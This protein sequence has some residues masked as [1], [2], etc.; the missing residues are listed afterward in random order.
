MPEIAE[1][2]IMARQLDG[3][4]S[5]QRLEAVQVEDDRLQALPWTQLRGQVVRTVHRRGKYA[6]AEFAAGF[7]LCI[8]YRMTGKTVLDPERSRA[9]RLRFI[10]EGGRCVA[11]VDSRRFGTMDLVPTPDLEAWIRGKGLGPEPWPVLRSGDW[12]KDRLARVRSPIKVALMRQD[13]VAGLGNIA[14]A[15]VLFRARI[16]PALRPD[17]LDDDD[18]A[19]LAEAVP[20]FIEHTLQAEGGAELS[21]VNQGG[22]GSFSVYGK[23]GEPCPGCGGAVH[24]IAQAGRGT[25]FCPRCQPLRLD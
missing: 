2:E 22:E 19:R 7:S 24:R 17:T 9:A 5:G 3:W 21:Y 18:W 12:W 8:H 10:F 1:V 23:E 20:A 13:R 25:Y 4:V 16:H 14:A 6:I 15:E 11:F